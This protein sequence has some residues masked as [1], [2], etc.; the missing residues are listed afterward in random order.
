MVVCDC[1][2][3]MHYLPIKLYSSDDIPEMIPSC[4]ARSSHSFRNKE[5]FLKPPPFV[6]PAFSKTEVRT[7]CLYGEC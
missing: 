1:A 7:K 6:H 4:T 2:F 5:D 3:C